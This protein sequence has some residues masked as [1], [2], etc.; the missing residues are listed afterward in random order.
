MNRD[1]SEDNPPAL[2]LNHGGEVEPMKIYFARRDRR[3]G[4]NVI[5]EPKKGSVR[6][7]H[8]RRKGWK[9]PAGLTRR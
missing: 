3:D 4:I 5:R 1:E 9:R 6:N 2:P 7:V 8:G